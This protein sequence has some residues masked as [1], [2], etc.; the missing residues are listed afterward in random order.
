VIDAYF[1]FSHNQPYCFF[2]EENFR[3]HFINAILPEYMIYTVLAIALRFVPDLPEP[4]LKMAGKYAAKAWK[5]VIPQCFESETGPSY[6]LVQATT[7]LSLVDFT[8]N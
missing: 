1:R 2:H 7:M 5:L 6:R 8:G 3:L 4:I